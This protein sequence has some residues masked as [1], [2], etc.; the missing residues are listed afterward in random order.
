VTILIVTHNMQQAARVS[1]Y[2]AYMYPGRNDRV[3]QDRR[4]LH[5]AQA[6][7]NRRLHHRPMVMGITKIVTDLGA[8]R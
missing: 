4:H 1:D 2:T 3:R 8:H 7:G 6:Q 5:Q